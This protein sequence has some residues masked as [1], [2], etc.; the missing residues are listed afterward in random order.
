MVCFRKNTNGMVDAY[1]SSSVVR[2]EN[3]EKTLGES[4]QR[5][6]RGLLQLIMT[7]SAQQAGGAWQLSRKGKAHQ[8]N[9]T[10]AISTTFW[11]PLD[12]H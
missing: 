11:E 10:F 6:E 3:E 4:I 2:H 7:I 12:R 9:M 1:M 8:G 5:R